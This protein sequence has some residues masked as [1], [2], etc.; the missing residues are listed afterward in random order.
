MGKIGNGKKRRERRR[1]P[2]PKQKNYT[3]EQKAALVVEALE[4]ERTMSEIG[5]REGISPKLL[6]NWKKEFLKNAYRAFSVSR[7]ERA[8]EEKMRESEERENALMAKIG[9]LTYE[10]DWCK[11]KSDEV[12]ARRK[13]SGY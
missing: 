2:M 7:D 6:S 5:A 11:K 4:G 9:Q 3:P 8:A 12:A 1:K 10:L 13:K